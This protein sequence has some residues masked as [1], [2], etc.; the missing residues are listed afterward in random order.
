MVYGKFDVLSFFLLLIITVL[1]GALIGTGFG[2]F[3]SNLYGF[4]VTDL[5]D[6]PD[7]GFS[8]IERDVLRWVNLG[9]QLC[10]FLFPAI[11]FRYLSFKGEDLGAS[12]S[13][14]KYFYLFILLTPIWILGSFPLVEWLYRQN[15]LL[16]LPE[17]LISMEKKANETLT[18]LLSM[19]D[20]FEF[21]QNLIIMAAIPALCEEW[22]FR[23]VIQKKLVDTMPKAW[24]GIFLGAL[25]FSAIHF[26]FA[27]FIPRM[28]LGIMLGYL[29]FYSGN[30][31]MAI[32]GHFV[33]NGVQVLAKYLNYP[34]E[35]GITQELT[36]EP[37][38]I[39]VI[40][41]I[42]GTTGIFYFFSTLKGKQ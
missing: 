34:L 9:S 4:S 8:R 27:G 41:S 31:W 35:E 32:W 42:L 33:F 13:I 3:V 38:A 30:I 2:T 11:I 16:P 40:L 1:C 39:G 26:Q 36:P 19:E 23:G 14:N 15:L 6:V 25:I 24:M 29:Y 22:L 12:F 37:T 10:T 18:A 20:K 21:I 7:S 28:F 5:I 17:A